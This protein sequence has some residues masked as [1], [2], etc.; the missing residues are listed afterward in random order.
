MPR[1]KGAKDKNPRLLNAASLDNL[2]RSAPGFLS[3]SVRV[4]GPSGDVRWFEGMPPQERGEVVTK[5]R[6]IIE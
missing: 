6:R 1:T 3:A 4:Y 2:K 5:A